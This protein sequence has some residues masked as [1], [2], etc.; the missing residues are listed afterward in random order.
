MFQVKKMSKQSTLFESWAAK[1]E[2]KN[3]TSRQTGDYDTND[4]GVVDLCSDDEDDALL[5]AAL[6]QSVEEQLQVNNSSERSLSGT[7]FQS[8]NTWSRKKTNYLMEHTVK[9]GTLAEQ[10]NNA[11]HEGNNFAFSTEFDESFSLDEACTDDTNIEDLPE[12]D[13]V[14]GRMWIYPTNYPVRE[15]QYNIVTKSL[16]ENTLVVLPTG[17]GKT[18]IAAVVMYNFYR[19]YPRGKIVFMAPTKPLVAQ[20]IEACYNIMGI[21]QSD[22]AEMT[23]IGLVVSVVL[24][25]Y[26]QA[27]KLNHRSS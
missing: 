19:W 9:S 22:T 26:D 6:E 12:F 27:V 21:P 11:L 24:S 14:A 2:K 25:G 13:D 3:A 8:N 10:N 4:F 17:L 7:R 16:Y 20:Q 15:Y 23:G 18:F 5:A 1:A